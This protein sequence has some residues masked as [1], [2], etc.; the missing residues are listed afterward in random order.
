LRLRGIVVSQEHGFSDNLKSFLFKEGL[1][2]ILLD[3]DPKTILNV[4][5]RGDWPAVFIDCSEGSPHPFL[6]H[7]L[8]HS[9]IGLEL[10][11]YFYV[12]PESSGALFQEG[13]QNGALDCWKRPIKPMES[14][15]SLKKH[16]LTEHEKVLSIALQASKQLM[17]GDLKAAYGLLLNL[18]THQS[19]QVRA[20]I[21]LARC[22]YRS[23]LLARSLERLK[24]VQESGGPLTRVAKEI[25]HAYAHLSMVEESLNALLEIPLETPN[26]CVFSI[27]EKQMELGKFS[28]ALDS[29]LQVQG[30][31]HMGKTANEYLVRIL[32]LLGLQNYISQIVKLS[33]VH[34]KKTLAQ[35]GPTHKGA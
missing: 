13:I 1:R 23:G 32:T 15:A 12:L 21:A 16:F 19:F 31:T 5:D 2:E 11:S 22:E 33:P 8:Y 34:L 30:D 18:R 14:T 4:I 25:S 29:L 9:T 20:D 7:D 24:K 3:R 10:C 17:Q 26:H 27:V 35:L 28:E 6:V